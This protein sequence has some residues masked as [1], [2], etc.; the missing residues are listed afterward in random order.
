MLRVLPA[1]SPSISTFPHQSFA[2]PLHLQACLLGNSLSRPGVPTGCITCFTHST[3]LAFGWQQQSLSKNGAF[4]RLAASKKKKKKLKTTFSQSCD[5]WSKTPR[6]AFKVS[7]RENPADQNYQEILFF[8]ILL[9]FMLQAHRR[10]AS[11]RDG[12][13]LPV[14]NSLDQRHIK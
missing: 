10:L 11:G 12:P 4:I 5:E 7:T 6:D 2:K 13:L 8:L 14:R 9:C 3:F 1:R